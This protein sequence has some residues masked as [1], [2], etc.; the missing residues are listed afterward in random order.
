MLI[1]R[2]YIIEIEAHSRGYQAIYYEMPDDLLPGI[3]PT[4]H[5]TDFYSKISTARSAAKSEIRQGKPKKQ[6]AVMASKPKQTN[7]IQL[8]L[9]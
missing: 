8:S 3:Q 6:M 1:F 9:I 5:R 2:S 4:V 7:Y